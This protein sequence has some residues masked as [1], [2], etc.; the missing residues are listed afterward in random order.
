MLVDV[1]SDVVASSNSPVY[2]AALTKPPLAAGAPEEAGAAELV[3]TVA[4]FLVGFELA[5]LQLDRREMAPR[6]PTALWL[7]EVIRASINVGNASKASDAIAEN[8]MI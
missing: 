7:R 4:L 1:A 6:L 3:D 8:N 5:G 2:Q